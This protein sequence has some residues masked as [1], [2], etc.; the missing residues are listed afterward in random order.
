MTL[1]FFK[2]II[3]KLTYLLIVLKCVDQFFTLIHKKPCHIPMVL[4][5]A[6]PDNH[7]QKIIQST[8]LRKVGTAKNTLQLQGH[9]INRSPVNGKSPLNPNANP[10]PKSNPN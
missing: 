6:I 3:M 7:T 8:S 1:I 2:Q 4:N 5:I 10:W 9:T